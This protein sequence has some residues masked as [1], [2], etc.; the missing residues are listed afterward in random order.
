MPTTPVLPVVM[1]VGF[2]HDRRSPAQASARPLSGD[3][4][5]VHRPPGLREGPIRRG[6]TSGPSGRLP[7]CRGRILNA[8]AGGVIHASAVRNGRVPAVPRSCPSPRRYRGPRRRCRSDPGNHPLSGAFKRAVRWHWVGVNADV[9]GRAAASAETRSGAAI[10]RRCDEDLERGVASDR[11]WGVPIWLALTTGARR[12]NVRAAVVARRP[13]R[14]R[15]D[16]APVDRPTRRPG[17]G[18]G[19]QDPPAASRRARSRDGRGAHRALGSL[20]G[21]GILYRCRARAGGLRVLTGAGQPNAPGTVRQAINA[22]LHSPR[23]YNPTELKVRSG[24][25]RERRRR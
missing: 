7:C 15:A 2:A 13:G 17:L 11:D 4:A 8:D 5:P 9:S 20:C 16:L 24:A 23:H 10:G 21:P 25:P 22:T 18:E 12:R 6:G 14:R 19:H 3:G 1:A